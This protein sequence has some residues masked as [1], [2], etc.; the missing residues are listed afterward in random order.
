MWQLTILT[1][2]TLLDY[3]VV[4]TPDKMCCVVS[5]TLSRLALSLKVKG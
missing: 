2:Q 5:K 3:Y 1:L 4:T